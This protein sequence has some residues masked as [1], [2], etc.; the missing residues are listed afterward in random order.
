M[1]GQ[2]GAW[3]GFG[4]RWIRRALAATTA[5]AVTATLGLAGVIAG[6]VAPASATHLRAAQLT[7]TRTTTTAVTFDLTMCP[8]P[9]LVEARN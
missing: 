3:T 9:G 7:W 8:V 2:L 1:N 5:L 6:M 4:H